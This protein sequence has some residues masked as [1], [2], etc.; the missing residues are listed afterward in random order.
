[1]EP[2]LII[3]HGWKMKTYKFEVTIIEGCDEWWNLLDGPALKEVQE[4]LENILF[5]NGFNAEAVLK[6]FHMEDIP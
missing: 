5:N 6:S 2:V 1:M 4:S 3:R